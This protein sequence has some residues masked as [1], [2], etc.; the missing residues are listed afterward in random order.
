MPYYYISTYGRLYSAVSQKIL[1]L[2]VDD[3]G[4]INVN[5]QLK[6]GSPYN[7]DQLMK[8]VNRLVLA[9][10]DPIDG[11]RDLFV[12]HKDNVRSNNFV[13]NLEW[14]TPKQNTLYGIQEGYIL[15]DVEGIKNPLHKLT[16]QDVINIA[17]LIKTGE[18]QYI[19]IAKM[20]NISDSVIYSIAHNKSWTHL[21]LGILPE[22]LRLSKLYTNNEIHM[23]CQF[24]ESHD[25]NNYLLYPSLNSIFVDCLSTTG[26]NKKYDV[27]NI[28]KF[29][30]K[31]L[32]KDPTYDIITSKYN[33]NFTR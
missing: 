6:H 33:Y 20:F 28:R 13:Y 22:H 30:T 3:N 18:Y 4:Y 29:L 27:E 32:R 31:I 10:F 16:E 14:V 1:R 11:W 7:N 5:L 15:P 21:N 23:I 8:R 24:F 19:D 17:E 2:I 9:T 25:I 26:L 12:H